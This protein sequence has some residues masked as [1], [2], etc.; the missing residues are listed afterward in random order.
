MQLNPS[1]NTAALAL[2]GLSQGL[3]AQ[4]QAPGWEF[5]TAT[6]VYSES[7]G[8]VQAVEPKLRATRYGA[9]GQVLSGAVT[10]DALTGASPNGAAPASGPQTFTT[11][12]GNG[13]Y[14][15]A[16]GALPLD[17]TFR[18]TRVALDA[19][20]TLP[21]G[22][23]N[24]LTV[25]A[26]GSKEYDYLST[27][28][29]VTLSRDFNL[30][31]TTVSLGA[32]VSRDTLNP[33]GGAPQGLSTVPAPGVATGRTEGNE[34]KQILDLLFSVTQLLSPD[35]LMVLS[36]STS[37][38]D[39]YLN[40]PYKLLSVVGT[41]GE[42]L[43]YV[44]E[45][46]PESRAKQ[47]LYAQYKHFVGARDVWDVSLRYLT[48]DWG[49]ASQTLDTRYRWN[50]SETR[51]LEPHLRYYRQSE[52]EFYRAALFDGEEALLTAASADPRLGR[53]DAL[54]LGVQ[55]GQ[56][57]ASGNSWMLRL[58]GYTQLGK[59]SGVPEAAAAGLSKFDLRPELSAVMLSAGY[60]FR[61]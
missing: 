13:Y 33:V 2:L 53:F 15:A 49:I 29:G 39:G 35:S 18:D 11:P 60:R 22:A 43:R 50:F 7:G 12:S 10:V 42:P 61:W 59:T 26:T 25:S 54:T 19:S 40:D 3:A 27:G 30:R 5:D 32:N 58:E 20:Y 52:A 16:A 38:S 28:V 55:Y 4:T 44:Y 1:L 23:R 48:D 46:R 34:D 9:N 21:L 51:Y 6:L 36:Y 17:D 8:R 41:D 37:V 47:A 31:N 57:L 56:T 45:S 24:L 14:E